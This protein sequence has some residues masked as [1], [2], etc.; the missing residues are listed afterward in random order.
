MA[1]IRIPLDLPN[2]E[3][4]SVERRVPS[5]W[6]ITVESTLLG[7]RCR[8]CGRWIQESHGHDTWVEV[9]H[10]PILDQPV[11][12]R[13][14]P[15]RD[16]CP[17]CE[18]GP[19]TPQV[20]SWHVPPSPFTRAYEDHL[21]KALIHSTVQD[22]SQKEGVGYDAVLGGLERRVQATVNWSRFKRLEVIGIDELALKKGQRD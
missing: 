10:L 1:A 19:T 7:T 4:M 2:V 20:L 3:V 17:Y 12:I 16:R 15:K 18:G 22:V 6:T 21:L 8:K 13:Y 5:G 14:R 11:F 9:Q